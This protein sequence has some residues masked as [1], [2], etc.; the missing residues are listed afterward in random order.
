MAVWC[1]NSEEMITESLYSLWTSLRRRSLMQLFSSLFALIL[2]GVVCP[3]LGEVSLRACTEALI[4]P[5]L[6]QK[7]LSTCLNN[8]CQE[9]EWWQCLTCCQKICVK[10]FTA[11]QLKGILIQF[12]IQTPF[13]LINKKYSVSRVQPGPLP[14]HKTDTSLPPPAMIGQI[15]NNDGN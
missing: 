10:A 4:L 2:V 6:H 14:T 7:S 13:F 11:G 8:T 15:S 5:C 9:Q 12:R 3:C 1:R